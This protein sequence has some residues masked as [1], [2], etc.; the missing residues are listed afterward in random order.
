VLQRLIVL[1]LISAFLAA[2]R[3]FFRSRVDTSL[4]VLALTEAAASRAERPRP[5]LLD[6]SAEHMA[7]MVGCSG[8][9]ETGDGG[10]MASGGLPL[11]LAL[12]IA[13]TLRPAE[14]L[15]GDSDSHPPHGG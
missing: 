15:R 13:A 7:A 9:C 8:D 2:I 14:V 1:D 11:V 10:R 6:H 4:E 12:E 3:V 5:L